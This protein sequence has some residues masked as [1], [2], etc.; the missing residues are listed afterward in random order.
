MIVCTKNVV[1]SHRTGK[2]VNL[3]EDI[4]VMH[5]TH[6]EEFVPVALHDNASFNANKFN[7]ATDEENIDFNI[8]RVP[9]SGVKHHI[10]STFTT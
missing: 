5:A 1:S 4:R 9:H 8:P 10:T 3:S 2:P 7:F 6:M